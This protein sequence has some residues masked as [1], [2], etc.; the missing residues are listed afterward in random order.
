VRVEVHQRDRAVRAGHRPQH[1]QRD[2]VVA[3][4]GDHLPVALQQ[5]GGVPGDLRHGLVDR[6]RRHGHVP[7]VHDLNRRERAGVQLDVMAGPQ[8]PR[9]LPDRHRAEPGARPVGGAAVERR[10]EHGDVV[11]SDPV[12]FGKSAERPGAGVPGHLPAI[13][14]TY[15]LAHVPRHVDL[16]SVIMRG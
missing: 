10:A 4:D 6:E 5:L 16:P 12:D 11:V 13:H 8:V 7:G 3:A 14:R 2:R 15:R 1:R 9:C